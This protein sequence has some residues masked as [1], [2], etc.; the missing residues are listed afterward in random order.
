MSENTNKSFNLCFTDSYDK[1]GG[2]TNMS[3]E[4]VVPVQFVNGSGFEE[5]NQIST[6][7]LSTVNDVNITATTPDKNR[8]LYSKVRDIRV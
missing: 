5:L 1:F 2:I 3:D 7:S 8:E 6:E 4:V